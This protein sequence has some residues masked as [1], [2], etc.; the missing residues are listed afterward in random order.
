[1]INESFLLLVLAIPAIMA[2]V[3]CSYG[4]EIGARSGLID[5]PDGERKLHMHPTPLVGGIAV[6]VPTFLVTAISMFSVQ[7]PDFLIPAMIAAGFILVLGVMDDRYELGAT[8]RLASFI[9]AASL[10]LLLD[11][12]FLLETLRMDIF[13]NPFDVAFGSAASLVTLFILVGFVNASNMADGMN[14]QFLGSVIIWSIF[15]ALY[16]AAYVAPA[17]GFPYLILALTSAIAFGFNLRG[18]LFTGSA[19]S[20][21]ASLFIG[22]SAIAAYHLSAGRMPAG[23]PMFWFYLPVIDCLRLFA[24]RAAQCRSPL[25]PDRNHFHHILQEFLPASGALA[26]YLVLLAAPGTVALFD[27]HFAWATFAL[28]FTAYSAVLA[29]KYLL[30]ANAGALKAKPVT[31]RSNRN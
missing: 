12:V 25:S 21:G 19:G 28:C 7:T 6:L 26:V 16:L 30:D 14:G 13:G 31:T 5:R 8:L 17:A 2:A 20:Y 18:A 27:H 24:S 23:V 11:P 9:L 4:R 29:G 22:L 15:L 10:A 1:M 3:I